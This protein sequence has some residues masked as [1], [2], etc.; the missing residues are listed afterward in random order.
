M[1]QMPMNLLWVKCENNAQTVVFIEIEP[2][3]VDLSH[4]YYDSCEGIYISFG[5]GI[6]SGNI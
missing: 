4:S 1:N 3:N 6:T 2:D 5:I